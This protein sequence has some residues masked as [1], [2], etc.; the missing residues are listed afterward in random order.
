MKT[1]FR[2]EK[3]EKHFDLLSKTQLPSVHQLQKSRGDVDFS[4]K[5]PVF[6]FMITIHCHYVKETLPL[7]V[8]SS[9]EVHPAQNK[10]LLLVAVKKAGIS[11]L[12]AGASLIIA[13]RAGGARLC[14][15]REA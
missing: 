12:T 10:K 8:P 2:N 13:G 5:N 14:L 4:L 6:I 1:Q 15:S 9:F 3:L 7:V 11:S